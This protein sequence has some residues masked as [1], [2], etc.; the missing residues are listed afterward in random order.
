MNLKTSC[1][2]AALSITIL[3]SCKKDDDGPDTTVQALEVSFGTG[4]DD[5]M[6]RDVSIDNNGNMYVT[7]KTKI[8]KLDASGKATVFAG[9]NTSGL[10]DGEGI[11]ASFKDIDL[12]SFDESNNLYVVDNGG[13]RK[14]LPSGTVSTIQLTDTYF[15]PLN[16][17]K[18]TDVNA[19][20]AFNGLAVKLNNIYFS[21]STTIIRIHNGVWNYFS[22]SSN[23]SGPVKDGAS[24]QAT[25]G[26]IKAVIFDE[27]ASNLKVG[28]YGRLRKVSLADS[29][30]TTAAGGDIAYQD[31]ALS[32][33]LFESF[34][35]FV[36]DTK[37]NV[38]VS[39]GTRIRKIS[40]D[41]TVSTVAGPTR[42]D[43]SYLKAGGLAIKDNFLYVADM[44]KNAT[45]IKIDLSKF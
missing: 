2:V 15:H 4:F 18:S 21:H 38:Y 25:F 19:E 40:L 31:G 13:I 10:V 42:A 24:Q 23:G 43:G 7:G 26:K 12:I 30:V 16:I 34:S 33:A 6:L 9:S 44:S 37:G 14:I 3:I 35:D 11:S 27:T 8:Y 28:D 36:K 1:L 22:G 17:A 41:G 20:P 45:I 5:E 39:S 32:Q 29:S